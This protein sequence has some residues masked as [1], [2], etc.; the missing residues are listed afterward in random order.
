[1]SE[2]MRTNIEELLKQEGLLNETNQL[3]ITE[4]ASP[5]ILAESIVYLQQAKL[6]NQDNFD[7][8]AGH[9]NPLELAA[10]FFDLKK[11]GIFHQ[12]N[13][14]AVAGHANPRELAAG[15]VNLAKTE[16]L[17]QVTRAVVARHANPRELAAIFSDLR[18]AGIF[19]PDNYAAVA[20]HSNPREL[21][22]VFSDLRKAG[23]LELDNYAAV[24]G[25]DRPREF[26]AALVELA[27]TGILNPHNRAA[28]A[29][30][31]N[32]RDFA[33]ALVDLTR[34]GILNPHNRAAIAGHANPRELA[35]I[36]SDLKKTGI[37]H[38][39]NY[40]AV[41]GHA[42]P[43]ELA[44]VFSDLRK[45]GILELDNYAAVAG[46][47]NPR[48][49]AA[50]FLDLRKAG[51]LELDNYAAVAGHD[52]PRE[53]AAALV[54][55][56]KTG[57]LNQHNRAAVAGHA[58]PHQLAML[59]IDLRQA[60][61]LTP[62][63][64]EALLLPNHAILLSNEVRQR[65]WNRIPSHLLT[66][67]NYKR[68]LSA[69]EHAYPLKELGRVTNIILGISPQAV[70]AGAGGPNPAQNTH[71][72]SVY[73]S[74]SI[75]ARKLQAIYGVGLNLDE[76][77][78]DIIGYVY[79]LGDSYKNIVVKRC[80]ARITADDYVF[81]DPSGVSTRELLA[82]AWVAIHDRDKC[83]ATLEDALTLFIDGLYEIQRG[84]NLDADNLDNG[85]EDRQICA[86]GTFNKIIEKL[87]GIYP[88]VELKYV[89]LSGA[90]AKFLILAQTHALTYLQNLANPETLE[91]Y[92]RILGL[93]TE[94]EMD[95][96]LAPIWDAIKVGVGDALWDEFH[97][98]YR[99]NKGDPDFIATMENG[100]NVP[101]V[102]VSAFKKQIQIFKDKYDHRQSLAGHSLWLNR[103]NSSEEQ[104]SFDQRYGL[105]L[106]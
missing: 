40:A 2:K 6:L 27:K 7:A 101:A 53:F 37:F 76:I 106:R 78:A 38:P 98:A 4:H 51:I 87:N 79:D 16:I 91:E 35:A 46:H 96:S 52:R 61:I 56:A 11:A 68:L 54:D 89:T 33:A 19:H 23:I 99:D 18:K 49:L 95:G 102:D 50:V 44:V 43:R 13:Y 60:K 88:D 26:A 82:L 14:A 74:V 66:Q 45:A 24:A 41:A 105:V 70:M 67:A 62:Q 65:I 104:Q 85:A 48:E 93:L 47:D 75:S 69:A 32:P 81:T 25:H 64:R 73:D 84:Y 28:V 71:T 17:N 12:D 22:A 55:L 36:F 21:A 80:I 20:G 63:N 100:V 29:G 103:H 59:F 1:M 31:A 10:I 86:P 58:N 97:Q 57:I 39:D 3:R 83:T 92:Q 42:N 90:N 15:L 9:A 30:H 34:T 72:A 77:I 5:D 8:V 94:L